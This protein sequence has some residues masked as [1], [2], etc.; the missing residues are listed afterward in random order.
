MTYLKRL[1]KWTE[2]LLAV[3]IKP[4]IFSDLCLYSIWQTK[5]RQSNYK[6][7]RFSNSENNKVEQ[8]ENTITLDFILAI[9]KTSI[10]SV[11]SEFQ[12]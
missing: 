4:K 3:K 8:K 2:S 7:V 11:S 5:Q 10:N 12:R 9:M 1:K 6:A